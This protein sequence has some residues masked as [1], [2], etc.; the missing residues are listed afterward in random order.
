MGRREF[1]PSF[2]QREIVKLMTAVNFSQA[3]ICERIINPMTGM[4]IDEKTLRLHFREEL[5]TS[6][7]FATTSVMQALFKQ[8]T[9]DG[10][11]AV[12]AAI[13][14]LKCK[15]GWKETV[16]VEHTLGTQ[17]TLNDFYADTDSGISGGDGAV[18]D[19]EFTSTNTPADS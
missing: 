16:S 13:F 7:E 17:R 19:A 8:A 18:I 5:D 1:T 2:K 12:T 15:A 9:G 4:P 3:Q 11:G 14:W 10:K 6:L